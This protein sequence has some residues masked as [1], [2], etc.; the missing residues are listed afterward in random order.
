M[1]KRK[2]SAEQTTPRKTRAAAALEAAPMLSFRRHVGSTS[3][4]QPRTAAPRSTQAADKIKLSDFSYVLEHPWEGDIIDCLVAGYQVIEKEIAPLLVDELANFLVDTWRQDQNHGLR[5]FSTP[6][7]H[8]FYDIMTSEDEAI[9]SLNYGYWMYLAAWWGPG[10]PDLTTIRNEMSDVWGVEFPTDALFYP[11]DISHRDQKKLYAGINLSL[12]R[13]G[14]GLSGG[15]AT[16]RPRAASHAE[17]STQPEETSQAQDLSQSVS[18]PLET[19]MRNRQQEIVD[20]IEKNPVG[21]VLGKFAASLNPT[22]RNAAALPNARDVG[23]LQTNLEVARKELQD[24]KGTVAFLEESLE[25]LQDTHHATQASLEQVQFRVNDLESDLEH[26]QKNNHQLDNQNTQLT[27]RLDK[28]QG[29]LKRANKHAGDLEAKLSKAD[30][31]MDAFEAKLEAANERA[32]KG[33]EMSAFN[34]AL[35][36]QRLNENSAEEEDGEI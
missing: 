4:V 34:H 24:T 9:K 13:E 28:L 15:R 12:D 25:S 30:D 19:Q 6:K 14:S 29:D 35:I 36:E 18:H 17:A 21:S 20:A 27:E 7:E 31:R 2:Q 22:C 33:I 26:V 8:R 16:S 10:H 11:P 32:K 23:R 3:H 5:T 1:T